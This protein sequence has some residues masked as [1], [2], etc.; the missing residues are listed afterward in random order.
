MENALENG[1]FLVNKEKIEIIYELLYKKV[2]TLCKCG[3]IMRA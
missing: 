2:L 3:C 1:Y